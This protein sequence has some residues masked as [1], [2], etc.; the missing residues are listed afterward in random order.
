MEYNQNKLSNNTMNISS[1]SSLSS[2]NIVCNGIGMIR[3]ELTD[4][5]AA[6]AI[7]SIT[8]SIL[9]SIVSIIGNG[10]AIY[11]IVFR[12]GFTSPAYRGIFIISGISIFYSSVT[13]I[14][15]T[16]TRFHDLINYHNCPL[17]SISGALA[18]TCQC[19]LYS[20]ITALAIDRYIAVVHHQ[21]YNVKKVQYIYITLSI[22]TVIVWM[23]V[24]T[25]AYLKILP[26]T[27]FKVIVSSYLLVHFV[28]IVFTYIK[29]MLQLAEHNKNRVQHLEAS[30][31]EAEI[32]IQRR[33]EERRQNSV[34]FIIGFHTFCM[35]AKVGCFAVRVGFANNYEL[36]YYCQRLTQ[37]LLILNTASYPILYAWRIDALREEM[38]KIVKGK[39]CFSSA[40]GS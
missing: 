24:I 4:S 15:L 35:L 18:Y 25:I 32:E 6:S 14:L 21:Y 22:F 36:E 9:L 26:P 11:V 17:K 37:F 30:M 8:T 3:F 27:I 1:N 38:V 2:I 23:P 34:L 29:V 13:Q 33:K 40:A 5:I 19:S 39:L 20:T 16:V 7:L 10:L 12:L 28:I 31:Q